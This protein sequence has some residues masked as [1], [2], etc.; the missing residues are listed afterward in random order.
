MNK[1]VGGD[2]KSFPSGRVSWKALLVWIC[3]FFYSSACSVTRIGC[4]NAALN[5]LETIPA[6]VVRV[7]LKVDWRN[8]CAYPG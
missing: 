7:L 1:A 3:V 2:R 4:A 6:H 5:R 8:L